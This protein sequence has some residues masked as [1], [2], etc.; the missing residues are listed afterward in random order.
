MASPSRIDDSSVERDRHNLP[1]DELAR[2]LQRLLRGQFT[3]SAARDFHADDGHE[4]D[5]V[6][7]ND[8]RQLLRIVHGVKLGASDFIPSDQ[9][10]L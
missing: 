5:V 3:T 1:R 2:S 4:R 9:G 10:F 7:A 8:L 6:L